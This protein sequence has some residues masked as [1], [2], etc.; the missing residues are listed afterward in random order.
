MRHALTVDVEDYFQVS[1][2]AENIDRKNWQ[3]LPSRV[4]SST[5][6]LLSLFEERGCKATFFVLG[7][8]AKYYPELVREI[9]ARGHEVASHGMSHQL[10]YQ[11]SPEVFKQ[12]TLDSKKL[13]ED[14]IGEQ[15]KGYR[16]A[17]YSITPQSVWALETLIEAGYEY[18][19]SIFP[20]RHDRYGMVGAPLNIHRAVVG[21][22]DSL[23]EFPLTSANVLG[24]RLPAAGGGYFRLYPFWLTQCLLKRSVKELDQPFVFYLHPWEVD[25]NQPRVE[26]A[27]LLSRFRHY[28]NLDKCLPRLD[29]LLGKF[30][31]GTM[32]DVI[33]QYSSN[34]TLEVCDYAQ[35]DTA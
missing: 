31:F 18:D 34:N 15:V 27:S 33:A 11:Q 1:A 13:L 21:S 5:K 8:V 14:I 32:A 35:F 22:H 20:V 28:N 23:I 10:I 26:G 7:W 3:A 16:A 9:H 4:V 2:F 25:P 29:K 17:S 12:E 24:H 30:E 6:L 19:S